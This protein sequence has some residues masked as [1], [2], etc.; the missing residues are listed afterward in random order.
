MQSIHLYIIFP[1][2]WK[3]TFINNHFGN[4][5]LVFSKLLS[6][7]WWVKYLFKV[8]RDLSGGLIPSNHISLEGIYRFSFSVETKA[9]PLFQVNIS[10]YSNFE[11]KIP[12]KDICE[13]SLTALRIKCLSAIKK[14]KENIII[15]IIQTLR[16]FSIFTWLVFLYSF[17]LWLS[18]LFYI[19]SFTVSLRI[20]FYF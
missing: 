14:F 6:V 3:Q 1:F 12:L 19:T 8:H 4:F 15:Y 17:M 9:E 20:L 2:K 13:F 18:V 11:V 7:V 10:L 16:E 5:G